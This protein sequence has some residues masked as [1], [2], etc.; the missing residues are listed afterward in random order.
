M[1]VMDFAFFPYRRPYDVRARMPFP[2]VGPELQTGSMVDTV[3][4]RRPKFPRR[5][6][7]PGGRV[8]HDSLGNAVWT[9]T[10]ASDSTAL[11]DTSALSIVDDPPLARGAGRV[12]SRKPVSGRSPAKPKGK[13]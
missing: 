7:G 5:R 3:K 13:I 12:T 10:R 1:S 11:P 6:G 4:M 2:L 9:R 8:E